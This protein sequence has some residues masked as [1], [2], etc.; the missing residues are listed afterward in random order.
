M[1]ESCCQVNLITEPGLGP[2]RA[3]RVLLVRRRTISRPGTGDWVLIAWIR[4]AVRR[5]G[6]LRVN[7]PIDTS[8]STS[9]R[10]EFVDYHD[11]AHQD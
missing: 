10:R 6:C 4:R 2:D 7:G 1:L 8:E 3:E 5:S 11:A 9:P